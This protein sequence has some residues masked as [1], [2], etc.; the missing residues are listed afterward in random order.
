MRQF[1][2]ILILIS[3]SAVVCA[4]TTFGRTYGTA[5]DDFGY[6]VAQTSDGGY[7]IGTPYNGAWSIIKTDAQGD[8]S[9]VR[10]YPYLTTSLNYPNSNSIIQT[11]DGNYVM[12]GGGLLDSN[13]FILKVNSIGDT[14]WLKLSGHTMYPVWYAKVVEDNYGNLVIVGSIEIIQ[15]NICCSPLMLKTDSNGNVIPSWNPYI[16]CPGS[17]GCRLR[18]IYIDAEG[19]YLVSGDAPYPSV[20]AP[21]LTKVDTA[22]NV[23]WNNYYTIAYAS[24]TGIIQTPDSG[25]ALVGPNWTNNDTT[26]LFKTDQDGNLQWMR[27]YSVVTSGWNAKCIDTCSGGYLIAGSNGNIFQVKLDT[28]YNVVW[29]QQYGGAQTESLAQMHSTSDG[30][31]VLVG[32]TNS[33]GAGL[34]DAYLIKT[35]QNGLVTGTNALNSETE[36]NVYPNP[37]TSETILS[38]TQEW[39]NATISIVNCLGQTVCEINNVNGQSVTISRGELDAGVYFIRITEDNAVIGNGKIVLADK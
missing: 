23:I 3:C 7:I 19:N 8:T 36:M 30:G 34:Y 28:A 25:Y 38:T 37:F 5:N 21:R 15:G 13:S 22:G 4:Q 27:K 14:L 18:E 9:W 12:V 1:L 26:F 39:N 16:P 31:S 6:S 29:V 2:F 32:S 11:N 24:V 33:F 20:P 35:D 10:T 17:P